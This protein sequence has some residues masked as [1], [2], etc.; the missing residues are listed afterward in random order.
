MAQIEKR[1]DYQWRARVRR[2]GYPDQTKTFENKA[3]AELWAATLESEIGRGVFVSR[4]AAEKTTLKE[5]IDRY[6]QEVTPTH[7]G[8]ESESIRL[9]AMAVRDI[10]KKTA[11]SLT[12]SDF[13]AYRDSRLKKVAAATVHR[14][15]GLFQQVLDQARREWGINLHD[16]PV[17]LVSRP[18]LDNARERRIEPLEEKYL[19]EATGACQTPWLRPMIEFALETA[20]RQG[21]LC[22]LTWDNI[23]LSAPSAHLPKTKNGDSRTVPLSTKAVSILK[24]MPRSIGGRVFPMSTNAVKQS[25]SRTIARALKKYEDDCKEA[26][27]KP[28]KGFL[29]DLH[30]H[31]L[32]HEATS[33]LA[34]KI[35]NVLML[36]R[37]TGHKDLQ[38]LKR[39]YHPKVEDLA[40]M[41]G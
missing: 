12:S 10:A 15:L 2:K 39:Y 7:R 25:W 19:F 30:F 29:G 18:R 21:E 27:N 5:L 11:A 13:A 26:E 20:M 14:E 28:R 38:M 37:I 41:L 35:P 31:D 40:K 33:R 23:D 24:E 9:K 32:R 3:D 17:K 8:Y 4:A 6:I 16:N 34:M 22:T 1:G 36:A